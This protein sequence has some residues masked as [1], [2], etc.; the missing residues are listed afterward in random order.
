M[1]ELI[2]RDERLLFTT[3]SF[4]T[5]L[6]V[7]L[8][9]T[10]IHSLVLGIIGSSIFFLINTVF[11][12]HVFFDDEIP[13]IRVMLGGLVLLLL[14]GIVSWA[15]LIVSNL[16]LIKSAIALCTLSGLCSMMNRLKTSSEMEESQ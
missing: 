11:L 7:S 16:D 12:G 2:V 1:E 13:F 5:V 15:I 4:A 14:L 8:N 6:I 3:V 10:F 9:S